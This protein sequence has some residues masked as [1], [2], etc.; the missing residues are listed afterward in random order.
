[1][2]RTREEWFAY[3]NGVADGLKNPIDE[4]IRCKDCKYRKVYKCTGE[5]PRERCELDQTFYD[6]ETDFCSLAVRRDGE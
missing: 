6:A 4:I 2:N 1:M 5:F 3:L